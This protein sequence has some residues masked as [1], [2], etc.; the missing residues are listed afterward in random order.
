M[1][2]IYKAFLLL[3]MLNAGDASSQL[4]ITLNPPGGGLKD[5]VIAN[6]TPTSNWGNFRNTEATTWTCASIL[7]NGR[8]LFQFDYSAIPAGSIIHSAELKLFADIDAVNCIVGQPTYGADNDAFIRKVNQA[9]D[10]NTV[11]WDTQPTFTN[12][13]E[14][15]VPASTTTDQDYIIDL[16]NMVQDFVNNPL[17]DFGFIFMQ[18][19]EVNFYKSLIF[20]SN[21]HPD[22]SLWPRMEISYTPL[23]Q[24]CLDFDLNTFGEDALIATEYPNNN[25]VVH[26][27]NEAITWTCASVL[28]LGRSL[29]QFELSSIPTN[30][31]VDSAYLELYA[32][33][34][35]GNGIAGSPMYG[36]DNVGLVQKITQAW[37]PTTVTCNNQPT[38]TNVNE[39]IIPQSMS[40][41]EDYRIDVTTLTQDMI[42]NPISNYG[43]MLRQVDEVNYYNSLIFS[44]GEDVDP[45]KHPNLKVCFRIP[46]SISDNLNSLH[47]IKLYPNPFSENATIEFYSEKANN[48]IE[49]KMFDTTGRLV[50]SATHMLSHPGKNTINLNKG[51]LVS[52]IYFITLNSNDK[53]HQSL[54]F[55]IE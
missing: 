31:I 38:S 23:S 42:S 34:N 44:T 6:Q 15:H 28:C 51:N 20:G 19:D 14:V 48:S 27:S 30:A 3:F 11:T 2:N 55:I 4:S 8:T 54:K 7:C 47:S 5:A 29:L 46:T 1:K 53:G 17:S 10:E 32:N 40:T 9:W 49:M 16:T 13:G 43:F 39:A 37:N 45:T 21:D 41:V 36:T 35:N 22:S 18:N 26:H 12:L 33:E 24:E 52:G 25:Y 50:R